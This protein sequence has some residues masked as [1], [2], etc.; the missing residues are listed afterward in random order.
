MTVAD[1]MEL[2]RLLRELA[3]EEAR[4]V[5]AE[6]AGGLTKDEELIDAASTAQVCG[7]P[8]RRAMDACFLRGRRKGTPH[9]VEAMAVDTP[10]GRRW[11]RGD[12]LAWSR[13]P[14]GVQ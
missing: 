6:C 1:R 11:R 3:R 10:H 9:P 4:T 5:L 13:R 8:S 14:S 12:L 2:L 7:W